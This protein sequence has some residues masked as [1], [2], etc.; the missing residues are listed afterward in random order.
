[1]GYSLRAFALTAATEADVSPRR[2]ATAA[3]PTV[4]SPVPAGVGAPPSV[5][6]A[7][8]TLQEG[9]IPPADLPT[10]FQ[11]FVRNQNLEPTS[12]NVHPS[13]RQ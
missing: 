13:H 7:A 12:V 8:R 11:S 5:A 6:A 1:M 4:N 2:D 10:S 3:V 9:S